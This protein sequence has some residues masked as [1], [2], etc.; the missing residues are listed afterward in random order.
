MEIWIADADG[1]NPRQITQLGGANFAPFFSPDG[2]KVIFTSNHLNPRGR[3][4]DLF[5]INVD[6]TGL[7]QITTDGEFDGF[8]MFDPSGTRL[9]WASNRHARVA[10][11]T[12]IFV[13][14]W[15]P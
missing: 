6:G 9:V 3:N 4:F 5:L 13:A 11:E 8:P 12:N 14:E 7:E 15:I 2:R 1:S 10:G